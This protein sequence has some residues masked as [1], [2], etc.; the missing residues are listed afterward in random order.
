MTTKPIYTLGWYQD[1]LDDNRYELVAIGDGW[2]EDRSVV[3]AMVEEH[4]AP[5][6]AAKQAAWKRE[7]DYAAEQYQDMVALYE[8]GRRADPGPFT[9]TTERPLTLHPHDEGY[10]VFEDTLHLS[11][12]EQPS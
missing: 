2:H 4:N 11:S 3:V 7:H 5:I 9:F 10:D 12:K 8:A 1:P 6:L